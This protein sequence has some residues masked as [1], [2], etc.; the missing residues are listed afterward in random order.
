MLGG[1]AVGLAGGAA[2]G[3]AIYAG[4]MRIPMRYLFSVTTWMIILL[5]AGMTRR[6]PRSWCRPTS[7]GARPPVVDTSG[8]LSERSW[9]GQVLYTLIGYDARP[10]G[11]QLLFYATTLLIIGSLTWILGRPNSPAAP[12]RSRGLTH[13]PTAAGSWP[14][15]AHAPEGHFLGWA[16]PAVKPPGRMQ[17]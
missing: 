5:A 7:A 16:F 2:V 14:S 13:P 3:V 9:P 6:A 4:L 12:N 10:S 8:I 1:G 11:I 17:C 15:A